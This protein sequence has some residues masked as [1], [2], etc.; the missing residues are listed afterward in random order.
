MFFKKQKWMLISSIIASLLLEILEF[1]MQRGSMELADL[2]HNTLGMMLGYS[3]LNIVLILLKK[4]EPD[5][6]MITY[7]FL[8]ITVSFV[9]LGI[10]ISYQMK[11]FGNMPLDPITKTD[12]TDVTNKNINKVKRQR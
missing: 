9:A 11:E 12:M 7:L 4:K 10:M 2:L 1:I 5:T 3:M 8:P 6:Q